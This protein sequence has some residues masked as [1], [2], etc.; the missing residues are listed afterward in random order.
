MPRNISYIPAKLILSRRVAASHLQWQKDNGFKDGQLG[1]ILGAVDYYRFIS[2]HRSSKP[3][4][5]A[6]H[7]SH[8]SLSPKTANACQHKI[9]PSDNRKLLHCPVCS[10]HMC[11]RLLEDI[12]EAW[13]DHASPCRSFASPRVQSQNIWFAMSWRFARL[14]LSKLVEANIAAAEAEKVWAK[15]NGNSDEYEAHSATKAL[16]MAE[17]FVFYPGNNDTTILSP[18]PRSQKATKTVRF[19]PDTSLGPTSRSTHVYQRLHASYRAGRYASKHKAGHVDTS[20]SAD[21]LYM[22]GQYKVLKVVRVEEGQKRDLRQE[23]FPSHHEGLA[24]CHE[25][26]G[27]MESF[28]V[29]SMKNAPREVLDNILK[30]LKEGDGIVIWVGKNTGKVQDIEVV[31]MDTG[32]YEAFEQLEMG[33][34][35][36]TASYEALSI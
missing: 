27:K 32:I 13:N 3:I 31:E 1:H 6:S 8:G 18:A 21:L 23:E 22:V 28:Y 10:V 24:F 33:W 36:L 7:S 12:T 29:K 15:S 16:W 25:L 5:D 34:T 2:D 30:H 4:T 35:S 20:F 26:W 14:E 17:N 19:T 9:H 11:L